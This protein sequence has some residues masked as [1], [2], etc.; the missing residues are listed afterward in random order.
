[1]DE[2]LHLIAACQLAG[3]QHTIGTLWMVNDEVCVEV[4]ELVYEWM[5]QHRMS[6]QSVAEGLHHAVRSLR[7][8]WIS[9]TTAWSVRNQISTEMKAMEDRVR[10]LRDV[11]TYE[12]I[13]L[14][15]VPYVHY[16]V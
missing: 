1:M 4:A 8:R 12:D 5:L 13:P 10:G 15:W 7:S 9:Q 16:G 14:H 6:D 11:E 2:G 3:F